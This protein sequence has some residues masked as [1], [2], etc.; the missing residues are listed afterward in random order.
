[1]NPDAEQVVPGAFAQGLDNV[2]LVLAGLNGI[3]IVPSLLRGKRRP[4]DL[5]VAPHS[6]S[7]TGAEASLPVD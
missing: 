5:P 6:D 2:Y 4:P 7:N 1:M 3:A